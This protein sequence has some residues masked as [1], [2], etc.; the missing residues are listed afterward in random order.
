MQDY[1]IK[2]L[3]SPEEKAPYKEFL[4]NL[5]H[6]CFQDP[7]AYEEFY[8]QEVYHKNQVYIIEDTAMLHRNPYDSTIK[9]KDECIDY[10]VGVATVPSKRRNGAMKQLLTKALQD[11][12]NRGDA[13]TF[14]MPAKAAYY[15]PFDFI[16]VSERQER[17]LDMKVI[18]THRER[19]EFIPYKDFESMNGSI[20]LGLLEKADYL[21]R[22]HKV[23]HRHHMIYMSL[24][25]KEKACQGGD[26]IFC[27]GTIGKPMGFFAY[28]QYDGAIYVEQC[29]LGV[30]AEV[31]MQEYFADCFAKGVLKEQP[32]Y[33]VSKLPY[34]VRVTN[35]LHC[36]ELFMMEILTFLQKEQTYYIEDL[37][38][39]ENTGLYR[40]C[41]VD[42]KPKVVFERDYET[43]E[44]D[45]KYSMEEFSRALI[46]AMGEQAFF[47]A[48][49]V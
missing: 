1:T 35:V 10:I 38:I 40:I 7:K 39:L 32:I 2:C 36:M 14:L 8:F 48:E 46:D 20:Q 11:L 18:Y 30:D 37:W 12:Y 28:A 19:Y 15:E 3:V 24:L 44:Y 47:F 41:D 25:Y 22:Q 6:E 26:V 43:K 4:Q 21:L 13:F 29:V 31:M 34:M 9:R 5:W 17:L 23:Y 16:S 49:I 42:G 27:K 45:K 33:H